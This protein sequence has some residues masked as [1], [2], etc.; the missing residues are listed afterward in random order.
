MIKKVHE[1]F[2]LKYGRTGTEKV[3]ECVENLLRF[4]EYQ[5]DEDDELILAMKEMNQ[6]HIDLNM[7]QDEWYAV[8]MLC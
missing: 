4:R 1:L 3:E 5:Y 6:R 7:S 2:Y 8:W